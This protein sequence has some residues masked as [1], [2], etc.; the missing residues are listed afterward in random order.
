MHVYS[1]VNT[2]VFNGAYSKISVHRI[3][4]NLSYVDLPPPPAPYC[5]DIQYLRTDYTIS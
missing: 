5:L 1:E 4:C 3:E 2:T